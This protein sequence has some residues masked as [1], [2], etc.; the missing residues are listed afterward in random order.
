[1]ISV[2][3]LQSYR[4]SSSLAFFRESPIG[5]IGYG[6]TFLG[7]PRCLSKTNDV[8]DGLIGHDTRTAVQ[9]EHVSIKPFAYSRIFYF[10]VFLEEPKDLS[11]IG[12]R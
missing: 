7:F 3:G 1:M 12:P 9:P 2:K 4:F 10:P 11:F 6:N 5:D 8:G